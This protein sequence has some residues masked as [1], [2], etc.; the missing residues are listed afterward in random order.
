MEQNI[1]VKYAAEIAGYV[2]ERSVLIKNGFDG[3][4]TYFLYSDLNRMFS[5]ESSM[6]LFVARK[7]TDNQKP[8]FFGKY[9]IDFSRPDKK[10]ADIPPYVAEHFWNQ[11]KQSVDDSKASDNAQNFF[12]SK[13]RSDNMCATN[14]YFTR[15][16][17]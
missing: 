4:E 12:Q 15:S 7:I 9:L 17:R 13:M 6:V 14:T 2:D 10:Y 16:S 8:I 1:I 11:A 5:A 3:L